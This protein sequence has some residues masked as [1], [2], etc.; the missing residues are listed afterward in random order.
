MGKFIKTTD[1]GIFWRS[2]YEYLYNN[3]NSIYFADS[4]NGY[5]S[6]SFGG[7]FKT[8]NS[9]EN[10]T[11]MAQVTNKNLNSIYFTNSS[12]GWAVGTQET[13]LKTTDG[14]SVVDISQL[15]SNIPE[16]FQ[17]KQNYP[18]PFNPNTIINYELRITSYAKLVVYDI[19]GKRCCNS[20]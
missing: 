14:G 18:N 12:T 4:L 15:S 13:I 7:I 9:G 3:I 20:W 19:L 16:N 10:W 6:G 2:T 1:N 5:C 11:Q 17:L 8:T